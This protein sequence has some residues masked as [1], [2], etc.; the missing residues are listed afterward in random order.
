MPRRKPLTADELFEEYD[1][2]PE[3]EQTKFLMALLQFEEEKLSRLIQKWWNNPEAD[4]LRQRLA[5]RN[6]KPS[7]ET[8]K[9]YSEWE[10]LKAEGKSNR[11]IARRYGRTEQAVRNGLKRLEEWRQAQR[12]QSD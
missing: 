10:V 7:P 5:N 6:R 9:K 8:M 4:N 3:D 2:L 1:A 12:H 11:Q